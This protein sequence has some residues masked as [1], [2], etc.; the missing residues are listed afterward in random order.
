[1]FGFQTHQ[2]A[3]TQYN[4]FTSTAVCSLVVGVLSDTA[5]DWVNNIQMS[6]LMLLHTCQ[7]ID[8]GKGCCVIAAENPQRTRSID[9]FNK[10]TQ[11]FDPA[12]G[13]IDRSRIP[14]TA[15]H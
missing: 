6:Y 10:R 7:I 9:G 13:T 5:Q 12:C 4:S 11:G 15:L 2:T 8:A 14:I 3:W 1:M